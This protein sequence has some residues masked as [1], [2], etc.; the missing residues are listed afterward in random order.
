MD[1]LI[2]NHTRWRDVSKVR[3]LLLPA[4]AIE[5]L[6]MVINPA[7]HEGIKIWAMERSEKFSVSFI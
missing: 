3:S 4:A 1:E 5:V 2:N 7:E 6:K